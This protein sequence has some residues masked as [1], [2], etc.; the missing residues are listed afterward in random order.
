MLNDGK[1]IDYALGLGIGEQKGLRLISH[2]GA[3]AGFRTWLGYYP[4]IDAG[5]VVLG[6]VASFDAGGIGARIAE[7]FFGG[8]MH[9]KAP[10]PD[11]RGGT[12][13]TAPLPV[14]EDLGRRLAGVFVIDGGPYVTI[15]YEEGKLSAEVEGRPAFA[16]LRDRDYAFRGDVPQGD[17][18]IDFEVGP[19]GSVDRAVLHRGGDKPMRRLAKWEPDAEALAAYT[20][21][22]YSPELDTFYT[23]SLEGGKLTP[24]PAPPGRLRADHQGEGRVRV[25]RVVDREGHVRARPGRTVG[26]MRLSNGRVRNLRFERAGRGVEPRP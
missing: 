18:R 22:Y 6:N 1:T 19:D 13:K 20:G 24:R 11:G 9:E 5:V 14:P 4:E 23:V 26:S 15:A 8:D 3:D 16:L 25:R 2:G 21:R 17:V 7:A 10:A 12:G